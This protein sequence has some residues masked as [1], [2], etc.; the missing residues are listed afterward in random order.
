MIDLRQSLQSPR[1]GLLDYHEDIQYVPDV[2]VWV[3]RLRFASL[4]G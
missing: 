1:V 3:D 2:L 4:F